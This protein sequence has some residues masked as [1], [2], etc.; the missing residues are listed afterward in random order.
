MRYKHIFH[1]DFPLN[2]AYETDLQ[3]VRREQEWPEFEIPQGFVALVDAEMEL[4]ALVPDKLALVEPNR[5][6]PEV[7]LEL[8]NKAGDSGKALE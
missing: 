7:L 6:L 3:I 8:L 2:C 1:L 4:I 5:M